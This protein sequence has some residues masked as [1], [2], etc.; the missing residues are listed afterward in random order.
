MGGRMDVIAKLAPTITMLAVFALIFG[1]IRL[2]RMGGD[3]RTKGM[4]MLVC[5]VVLV[6]NVLIWTL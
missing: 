5:A 3:N 2:V 6:G 4:L 1:G